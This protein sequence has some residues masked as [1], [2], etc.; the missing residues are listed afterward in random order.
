MKPKVGF[1]IGADV[2]DRNI[3]LIEITSI[4][5]DESSAEGKL[6]RQIIGLQLLIGSSWSFSLWD[7]N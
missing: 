5:N 6:M 2:G 3:V 1:Y 7:S 4:N